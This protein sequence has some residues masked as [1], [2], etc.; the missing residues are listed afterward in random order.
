[1]VGTA[2]VLLA[3]AGALFLGFRG[4]V[5]DDQFVQAVD[6]TLPA[7]PNAMPDTWLGIEGL[8]R[9][10]ADDANQLEELDDTLS[11]DAN[12]AALPTT[13]S[14]DD[15]ST[16]S[17]E[18]TG[19]P[20]AT[21]TTLPPTSTPQ[22][23]TVAEVDPDGPAAHTL[24]PGDVLLE[25]DGQAIVD[26]NA[27]LDTLLAYQPGDQVEVTYLTLDDAG[28]EWLTTAL[29]TLAARPADISAAPADEW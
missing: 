21:A 28:Q 4:E 26:M 27:L 19:E 22:G 2:G 7:T 17:S 23:V 15:D 24:Q 6:T 12:A 9:D 16:D 29:V 1:V 8:S 13:T 11:A 20:A 10:P 18:T 25:V 5:G 14:S 3:G